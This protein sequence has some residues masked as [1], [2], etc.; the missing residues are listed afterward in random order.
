M[1]LLLFFFSFLINISYIKLEFEAGCIGEVIPPSF[2]VLNFVVRWILG[3][4][5]DPMQLKQQ[6]HSLSLCMCL[7]FVLIIK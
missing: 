6:V 3:W 7:L 4:H 5:P 1:G 2:S